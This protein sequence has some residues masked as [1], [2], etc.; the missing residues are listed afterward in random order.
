MFVDRAGELDRLVRAVRLGFNA[1]VA[2]ERGSG[3][4]SLLRHVDWTLRTV[5]QPGSEVG[6]TDAW[7]FHYVGTGDLTDAAGLLRRLLS[8]LTDD[9]PPRGGDSSLM[10]GRISQA[11]AQPPPGPEGRRPQTVVVLDDL[12]APLGRDLFGALR[13]ELWQL[14]IVWLVGCADSEVDALLVPPVDAFFETVIELPG[15]GARAGTE[16]ISRRLD[17]TTELAAGDL[18]MILEASHG[19]PRR[20]IDL[21]RAVVV[22]QVPADRLA[23][24]LHTR[25]VQLGGVGR[26][27]AML[28]AELEA[29]GP[30]SPSDQR[31]QQRMGVSRPRLINLLAELREAGLVEEVTAPAEGPGRPRILYQLTT[32]TPGEVAR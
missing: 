25:S 13:D 7:R 17:D 10:L 21:V 4:T 9:E 32:E 1:V 30:T 14:G 26:R 6:R 11:L 2:G 20:M 15:I 31:L 24:G 22:D 23:A 19:N 3:K 16:L 27:A 18:A 12:T 5:P 8:Q 29:L 28:A